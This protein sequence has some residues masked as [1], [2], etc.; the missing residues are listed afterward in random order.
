MTRAE[1]IEKIRKTERQ[2]E[3]LWRD[4]RDTIAKAEAR[5]AA[6][7]KAKAR[8]KARARRAA[9]VPKK[10]GALPTAHIVSG[11]LPT[12]GKKR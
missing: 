6:T 2:L 3:R 12:L 1:L 11:G 9:K 5:E 10:I 8:A 7:V 4:S